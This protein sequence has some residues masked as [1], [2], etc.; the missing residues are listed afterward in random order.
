MIIKF[1]TPDGDIY[2]PNDGNIELAFYEAYLFEQLNNECYLKNGIGIADLLK[3]TPKLNILTATE[4]EESN[5]EEQ[6]QKS[7]QE[8]FQQEECVRSNDAERTERSN[9]EGNSECEG[10]EG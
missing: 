3:S 4:R 10:E 2:R 9:D 1:S 6:Q 7:P 5:E 8:Q